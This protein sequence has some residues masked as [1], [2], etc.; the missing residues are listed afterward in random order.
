MVRIGLAPRAAGLSPAA[1]QQY[2]RITHA[3]LFAQVPGLVSYVQNHAVLA[4]EGTPL[5]GDPGFDIFSEVEFDSEAAQERASAGPWYRG[6]VIPDERHLLDA[7][8]RSF[9]MSTRH[10]LADADGAAACRVV[11]F[12]SGPAGLE[13]PRALPFLEG[14]SAG[15][16]AY[17]VHRVGGTLPRPVDLVV[18]HG[19]ASVDEA[20]A[21]HE[22]LRALSNE[23]DGVSLHAAT[24]ARENEVLPRRRRSYAE[25]LA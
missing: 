19:C 23:A 8:R 11:L 3:R 4:A 25:R 7:G 9:L 21:L 18:A 6:Q 14:G 5:L 1:A 15:V 20:L 10:R 24:I 17:A 13:D 16:T 2:W 22:R 12:L